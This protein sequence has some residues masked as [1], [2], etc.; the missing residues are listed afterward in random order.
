MAKPLISEAE[1]EQTV[2]CEYLV[3]ISHYYFQY[4]STKGSSRTDDEF[5]SP[6]LTSSYDKEWSEGNFK[7]PRKP[8][9]AMK[10]LLQVDCNCN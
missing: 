7:D 3:L 4:W 9:T 8:K 1:A 6:F 10:H 5:D 2:H